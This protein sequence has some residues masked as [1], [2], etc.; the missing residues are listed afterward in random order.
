[1]GLEDLFQSLI[2][3]LKTASD[4]AYRLRHA[5]FQSLIGRLKTSAAGGAWRGR[6]WVSIPHR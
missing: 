3:R 5:Q 4:G 1:M 2:G 6:R